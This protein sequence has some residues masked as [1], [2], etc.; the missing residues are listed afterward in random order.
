MPCQPPGLHDQGNKCCPGINGAHCTTQL[1]CVTS[2]AVILGSA[3]DR[4]PMDCVNLTNTEF[5]YIPRNKK[6]RLNREKNRLVLWPTRKICLG[7]QFIHEMP[8]QKGLIKP[9][10]KHRNTPTYKH[11]YIYKIYIYKNIY[12]YNIYILKSY[13]VNI[14]SENLVE[15]LCTS[16]ERSQQLSALLSKWIL[17][18]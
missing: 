18:D 17:K 5:T 3:R 1:E 16:S 8:R 4:A 12:I 6:Y 13:H 2:R 10:T 14:Y 15:Y 7:S 9:L 11:I